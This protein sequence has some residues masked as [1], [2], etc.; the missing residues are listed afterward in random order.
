MKCTERRP[1]ESWS[2]VANDLAANVGYE[3][4]GRCASSSSIE[5][6]RAAAWAASTDGSGPLEPY[7]NSTRVQPLSSWARTIRSR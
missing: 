6:S 7:A 2:S 1:P 5:S 3:T 4:F